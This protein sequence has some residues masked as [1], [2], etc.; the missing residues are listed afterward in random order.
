MEESRQE[1]ARDGWAVINLCLEQ[2]V[3]RELCWEARVAEQHSEV[4]R[5][6][7]H[8]SAKPQY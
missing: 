5:L 1:K 4:T 6:R 7:M 2:F 3:Y 8:H